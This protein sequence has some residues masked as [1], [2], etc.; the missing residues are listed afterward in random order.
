MKDGS[1]ALTHAALQGHLE[2][3][4]RLIAS[5]AIVDVDDEVS[6]SAWQYV[7]SANGKYMYKHVHERV[8]RLIAMLVNYLTC[9]RIHT[10]VRDDFHNIRDRMYDHKN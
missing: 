7:C 6:M 9:T 3:V 5:G 1:T 10:L 2:T 8:Y 4:S